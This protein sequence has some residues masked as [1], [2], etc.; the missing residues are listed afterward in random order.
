MQM[1]NQPQK[2]N[3]KNTLFI[4]LLVVV[5][6]VV[7]IVLVWPSEWKQNLM[8]ELRTPDSVKNFIT[9]VER[10]LDRYYDTY[11]LY[12][13]RIEDLNL[14]ASKMSA[15]EIKRGKSNPYYQ[16]TDYYSGCGYKITLENLYSDSFGLTTGQVL[17]ERINTQNC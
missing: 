12:P 6:F 17:Y 16:Y 9:S 7:Y 15:F 2:R 1:N 14:P 8:N 10:D 5:S 13:E 4:T 11:G 3:L